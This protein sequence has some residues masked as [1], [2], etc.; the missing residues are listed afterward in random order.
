MRKNLLNKFKSAIRIW[1]ILHKHAL[2]TMEIYTFVFEMTRLKWEYQI[3]LDHEFIMCG[4]DR[5]KRNRGNKNAYW[6]KDP[7]LLDRIEWWRDR[8][9][10]GKEIFLIW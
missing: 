7:N 4:F 8:K 3:D 10:T 9:K 2:Y 6:A 1:F 5:V